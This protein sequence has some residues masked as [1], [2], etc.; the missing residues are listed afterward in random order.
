M[1][2]DGIRCYCRKCHGIGHEVEMFGNNDD[3]CY[4]CW[5]EETKKWVL[6]KNYTIIG[7]GVNTAVDNILIIV[8]IVVMDKKWVYL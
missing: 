4:Y 2:V 1:S 7:N 8:T 6:K 5:K 3:L